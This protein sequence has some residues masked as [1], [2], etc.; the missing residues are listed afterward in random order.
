MSQKIRILVVDDVEE[1]INLISDMLSFEKRI[2]IVGQAS[3]GKEAINLVDKLKPDVVLM[4]INMPV[5]D[6]LRATEIITRDHP[7][8]IVIIMSVQGEVEYLKKAML[9]GAKEYVVKPFNLDDII[10]T[11]ITVYE[12][13]KKRQKHIKQ[14]KSE[15]KEKNKAKTITLFGTKG[16]VGKTTIALNTA[17]SIAKKTG[18]K[19]AIIDLDLQFGD[20]SLLSNINP[21]KTIVDV[22]EDLSNFDEEVLD[23]Y[24]NEYI[25]G[26]KILSSPIKPE[27]A[28]YIMAEHLEKILDILKQEYQYIVIDTSTNFDDVT[29][30]A[31]DK[32]DVILLVSTMDLHSIK[33]VKLG[34]EIM[35]SLNYSEKKVKLVI[36]KA[37]QKYGIKYQDLIDAL[38]K[39]VSIL[40]PYDNKTVITSINKGYPFMRHRK[41]GKIYKSI[42]KLTN[43]IIS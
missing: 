10:N 19:V 39:E 27:Q 15:G 7:Q 35:E 25:A 40:V 14:K 12:E 41:N 34:L 21:R 36:N 30:T 23:E 37:T 31:L 43:A 38:D 5:M 24:M 17:I 20:I 3:N 1:T 9:Y 18:E 2:E 8:S 22:L 29:L 33:N 26:I 13:E 42:K 28:E 6:G 32:S 16:G 4:D 11:I